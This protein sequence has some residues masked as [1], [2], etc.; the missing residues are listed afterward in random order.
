MCEGDLRKG[1]HV[2]DGAWY[3]HVLPPFDPTSY[4]FKSSAPETESPFGRPKVMDGYPMSRDEAREVARYLAADD[5]LRK[6]EL[7]PVIDFKTRRIRW[8]QL[9]KRYVRRRQMRFYK[10]EFMRKVGPE[11]RN[12]LGT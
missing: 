9:K 7:V 10:K 5:R 1:P 2:H 12:R 4:K 6:G 11:G 8:W 3:R